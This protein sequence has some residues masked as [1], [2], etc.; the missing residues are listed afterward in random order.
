MAER[1]E[2]TGGTVTKAQI[3]SRSIDSAHCF[4]DSIRKPAHMLLE[5][6]HL[7]TSSDLTAGT[8]APHPNAPHA[9]STSQSLVPCTS[10]RRSE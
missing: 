3:S 10:P 2:D 5:L 1:L 6:Y 9:S 8:G 4:T 7:Q